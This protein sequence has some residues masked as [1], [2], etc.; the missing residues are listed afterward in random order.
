MN[1][2]LAKITILEMVMWDPLRLIVPLSRPLRDGLAR[3]LPAS[4]APIVILLPTG[5][6]GKSV[7]IPDTGIPDG[8]PLWMGSPTTSYLKTTESKY[9]SRHSL[10]VPTPGWIDVGPLHFLLRFEV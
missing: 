6:R 7:S 8:A 9:W 5:Q 10:S 4:V 2:Q 1:D 3:V